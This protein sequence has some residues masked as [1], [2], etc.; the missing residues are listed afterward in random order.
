MTRPAGKRAFFSAFFWWGSLLEKGW[1]MSEWEKLCL[2]SKLWPRSL[3]LVELC[4]WGTWFC[5]MLIVK[6]FW[7]RYAPEDYLWV[8]ALNAGMDYSFKLTRVN[9]VQFSFIYL[10]L[11]V[12]CRE[13]L[14]LGSPWNDCRNWELICISLKLLSYSADTLQAFFFFFFFFEF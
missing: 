5:G 4:W 12:S 7:F 1:E 2:N 8:A 9:K 13:H 14:N 3:T 10:L 6:L 11:E